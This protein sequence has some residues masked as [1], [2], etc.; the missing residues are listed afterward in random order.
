MITAFL[1]YFSVRSWMEKLK[2]K[3]RGSVFLS[4]TL[5]E[6]PFLLAGINKLLPVQFIISTKMIEKGLKF[7]SGRQ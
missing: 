2:D 4:M 7:F 5:K 6:T 3:V 1:S